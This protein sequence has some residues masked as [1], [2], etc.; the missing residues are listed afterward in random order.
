MKRKLYRWI[1][2]KLLKLAWKF[3][4][5]AT[6]T[7]VYLHEAYNDVPDEI[8][9]VAIGHYYFYLYDHVRKQDEIDK[10]LDED[11]QD[12]N[13]IQKLTQA[14]RDYSECELDYGTLKTLKM[15]DDESLSD[16]VILKDAINWISEYVLPVMDMDCEE[17]RK[18]ESIVLCAKE[19]G[20]V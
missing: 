18:A 7:L 5:D 11:N 19:R 16:H 6:Y 9:N 17:F 12:M 20:V 10:W 1:T 2:R 4:E 15:I 8:K 14:I 3:S 13:K